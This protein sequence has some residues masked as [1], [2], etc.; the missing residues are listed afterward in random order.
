VADVKTTVT[1]GELLAE[2]AAGQRQVVLMALAGPDGWAP[3]T[4]GEAETDQWRGVLRTRL[5][6]W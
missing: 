1:D 2:H 5:E 4:S 3:L 6:R